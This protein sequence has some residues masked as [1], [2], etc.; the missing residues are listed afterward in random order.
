MTKSRVRR[1]Y[2]VTD[3]AAEEHHPRIAS[4]K[5]PD[6]SRKKGKYSLEK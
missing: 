1:V 4:T 5:D 2:K 3:P 6:E